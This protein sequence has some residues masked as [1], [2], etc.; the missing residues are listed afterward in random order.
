MYHCVTVGVC[1][2]LLSASLSFD[3]VDEFAY[4]V[5]QSFSQ[6]VSPRD[7]TSADPPMHERIARARSYD[8]ILAAAQSPD[9]FM[10]QQNVNDVSQSMARAH[11]SNSQHVTSKRSRKSRSMDELN[12]RSLEHPVS[13]G[14]QPVWLSEGRSVSFQTPYRHNVRV[15]Q[16]RRHGDVKQPTLDYS[17]PGHTVVLPSSADTTR[18]HAVTS[19]YDEAITSFGRTHDDNDD[20]VV[21]RHDVRR[22]SDGDGYLTQSAVSLL[23]QR[24]CETIAEE[25]D[26]NSQSSLYRITR[27]NK[28]VHRETHQNR[29]S[30]ALQQDV[31]TN[32]EAHAMPETYTASNDVSNDVLEMNPY[33]MHI[34]MHDDGPA[35]V[36]PFEPI[37]H[38]LP[39]PRKK[40]KAPLPPG[41]TAPPSG[42]HHHYSRDLPPP[43]PPPRRSH[44]L[45]RYSGDASQV[46]AERRLEEEPDQL[47]L[48]SIPVDPPP[49]PPSPPPPPPVQP[50]ITLPTK[51][52]A[53][54]LAQIIRENKLKLGKDGRPEKP[55]AAAARKSRKLNFKRKS[56][57]RKNSRAEHQSDRIVL[58]GQY[59]EGQGA[60]DPFY[61]SL[62]RDYS[63]RSSNSNSNAKNDAADDVT[64]RQS[65]TNPRRRARRGSSM[66]QTSPVAG[67][68]ASPPAK[69]TVQKFSYL[70]HGSLIQPKL[71]HVER[72]SLRKARA[73]AKRRE[74]S[75][76][77]GGGGGGGGKVVVGVGRKPT[78]QVRTHVTNE[79][80]HE[81][82]PQAKPTVSCY[83]CAHF[84]RVLFLRD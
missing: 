44:G 15:Q 82:S 48:C 12:S 70:P 65:R 28:S 22:P 23:R 30:H 3:D 33:A 47:S 32:S 76:R 42:E 67:R 57:E 43:L 20:A 38:Q 9:T 17:K 64:R 75:R 77:S 62:G 59:L 16:Q 61:S 36:T 66:R 35:G 60:R 29:A 81:W 55:A 10:R 18:D 51:P 7:V 4:D 56:R 71:R 46:L 5:Q 58:M 68:N 78:F 24:S 80:M 50:S 21:L 25:P 13:A 41:Q 83:V 1:V 8:D 49:Q 34:S 14:H 45:P 72:G 54:S 63:F 27:Q 79:A 74:S 84:D 6:P 40:Y 19:P 11:A 73:D 69:D 39:E 2:F 53:K 37:Y 26:R 31:Y 52:A